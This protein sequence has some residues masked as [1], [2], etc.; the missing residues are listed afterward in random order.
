MPY[1]YSDKSRESEEHALPDVEVFYR[2]AAAILAEG[3]DTV[4]FEMLENH[5]K[6]NGNDGWGHISACEEFEG[7]FYAF[8]FPGCLW[9]SDPIGPF[10][11]YEQ[12]LEAAREDS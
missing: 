7:W 5:I 10:D 8:G 3:K 12:A 2:T 6:N 11:T 1:E 9:D 4:W